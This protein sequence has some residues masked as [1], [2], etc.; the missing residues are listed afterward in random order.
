MAGR[1]VD[2]DEG[3]LHSPQSHSGRTVHKGVVRHYQV[4]NVGGW[5][6]GQFV[7][8]CQGVVGVRIGQGMCVALLYAR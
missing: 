7:D 5:L 4:D 8:G 1:L 6:E 3:K 2:A